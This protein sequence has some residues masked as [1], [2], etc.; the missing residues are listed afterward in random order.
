MS[1]PVWK[2][3][4]SFGLVN[5][6]VQLETAVHEKAIHFH[7]LSKDGACRLRRKLYC[8]ETGKEFDFGDTARG[9]EL[10]K[11]H[12]ALLDESE[13][14]KIKPEQG[15][16][17]EILQFI[18]LKEIDP[19]FFDRAYFLT[20]AAGSV[21]SYKLLYDA[22]KESERIALAHFVMRE[23]QYLAAIRVL[24]DGLVLHTMHYADEVEA[25][26]E[27]L[28]SSV[29]KSKSSSKEVQIARQL[30]ESMTK[31]LDLSEF[32]DEYREELQ[33]LIDQK[34]HGKPMRVADE[35]EKAAEPRTTNLMDA[36]RRSLKTNGANGNGRAHQHPPARNRRMLAGR[37]PRAA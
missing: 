9:I 18:E 24:G 19:V 4:I 11:G 36:L 7:M 8:P 6:P 12:Y 23:R 22:M 28:P 35:P 30:I 2:G 34:K 3:S 33:R 31:E 15:K 16:A 5:I 26:D 21:K 32:K 1:R 29:A 27:Q 37:K 13:I 20:P 25:I 17:I 14:K 10:G